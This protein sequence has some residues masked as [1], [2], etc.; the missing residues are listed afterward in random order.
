ML[1]AS[2]AADLQALTAS[3]YGA[4]ASFMARFPDETRS[5]ESWARRM[6]W[7]WDQN[8]AFEEGVPRG[9]TLTNAGSIVG[10]FGLI[11]SRV[12]LRS[13]AC[14]A[15]NVSSWRVLPEWR[16][17]SLRLLNAAVLH[18]RSILINNSPN[19]RAEKIF[20]AYRFHTFPHAQHPQKSVLVTR[21]SLVL[22]PK[23]GALGSWI[24]APVLGIAQW[25]RLKGHRNSKEWQICEL[26]RADSR[27]DELWS[28]TQSR[29]ANTNIRTAELLNWHCFGNPEFPK[30]LF[31]CFDGDR[32]HAYAVTMTRVREGVATLRW[33]DLW[34]EGSDLEVLA[35]MARFLRRWAT[36]RGCALMEIP[37]YSAT[38]AR[39]LEALG[40]MKRDAPGEECGF[41]AFED[42]DAP[43]LPAAETY[44]VGLQG[45]RGL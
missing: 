5:E 38:L 23:L 39:N 22:R 18:P 35:E 9:W 12:Q 17:E 7:W 2:S 41:Y 34:S 30:N 42:M 15:F 25:A 1:T 28:R 20:K 21:P 29:F 27:F 43:E 24:G 19:E 40:W 8:P 3:D 6:R 44:F 36:A 45:D 26:D 32:L 4:L 31:G 11:P 37:H 16:S 10:F 14:T 13:A 33:M